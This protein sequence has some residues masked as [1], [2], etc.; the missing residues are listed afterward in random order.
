MGEEYPFS[1]LKRGLINAN[2]GLKKRKI[3]EK[4]GKLL[5]ENILLFAPK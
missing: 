4:N 2:D 3:V 1:R 5:G